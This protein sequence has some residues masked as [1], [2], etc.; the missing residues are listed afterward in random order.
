MDVTHWTCRADGQA[1]VPIGEPIANIQIHILDRDL[2]PQP[3]GV[4]GEL[5][6][7]RYRPWRAA[8]TIAPV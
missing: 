3:A 6:I 1:S 8:I 4:A 2:N 7:G 5:Y